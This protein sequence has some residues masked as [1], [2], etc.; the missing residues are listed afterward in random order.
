MKMIFAVK[1]IRWMVMNM[2]TDE[3]VMKLQELRIEGLSENPLFGLSPMD[4]ALSMAIEALQYMQD[5]KEQDQL[6]YEREI[7]DRE[8][9]NG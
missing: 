2:T 4:E 8:N 7:W 9:D 1:V 5:R 6:D 3:A